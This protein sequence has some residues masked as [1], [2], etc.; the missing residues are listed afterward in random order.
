MA[1]RNPPFALQNITLIAEG[2]T[3][4]NDRLSIGSAFLHG[5]APLSGRSGILPAPTGGG[6]GVSLL[7][8]TLARVLPFRAV[9]QGTRSATQGQYLVVNDAAVDLPIAAQAAGVSRKDLLIANVRD[10]AFAPDTLDSAALQVITGTPAAS[11]PQEP[12]LGGVNLGNHLILG[13]FSVPPT[14]GTVT[15]TPRPDRFTTVEG[16]RLFVDTEAT[17][18]PAWATAQGF[19]GGQEAYAADTGANATWDGAA[20]AFYDT[21]WQTYTPTLSV[22]NAIPFPEVT[23]GNAVRVGRYKRNG[24]QTTLNAV[25]QLGT[26]TSYGGA[27]GIVRISYPPNLLPADAMFVTPG[28]NHVN[29]TCEVN[30]A[31][32]FFGGFV[33]HLYEPVQANRRLTMAYMTGLAALSGGSSA[34][35]NLTAAGQ[36]VQFVTT[37]ET[38]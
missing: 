2:H 31:S 32:G 34:T 28:S 33:L 12:A 25:V 17:L 4:Q 24:R 16:G 14:G 3:A 13:T 11:N 22:N 7:S 35:W 21:R 36:F 19:Q 5:A 23:Y 38:D 37:Y 26:T 29:G 6:G 9:I 18:T 15:F 8:N 30:S 1:V 10:S 20:W 27:N